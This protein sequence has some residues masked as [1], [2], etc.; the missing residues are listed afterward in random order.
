MESPRGRQ[1]DT[2][3]D[4]GQKPRQ[5]GPAAGIDHSGVG[6]NLHLR[7]GTGLDDL[8][9]FD[10]DAQARRRGDR[11]DVADVEPALFELRPLLDVQLD[12]RRVRTWLDTHAR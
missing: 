1:R 9:A 7:G 11:G 6:G 2:R 5:H 8:V 3:C 12:E 4:L 10:Q